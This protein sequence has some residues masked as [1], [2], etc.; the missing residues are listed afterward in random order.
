MLLASL[1]ILAAAAVPASTPPIEVVPVPADMAP[2][3]PLPPVVILLPPAERPILFLDLPLPPTELPDSIRNLARV[4]FDAGDDATWQRI[5]KLSRET[6]PQARAQI[7]AIEAEYTARRAE[8]LARAARERAERLAA[9]SM[10]DNWKGEVELGG[11]RLTGNTDS[12][13]IFGAVRLD[14]EGLKWKHQL[15]GRVDFQRADDET[16][17]DRLKLGWQPNY[18]FNEKSF[19]YGLGQYERDRFLGFSSRYTL[20]SGIG[21]GI[22]SKP[23]TKLSIQGGP[24]IRYTDYVDKPARSSAAGRAS[25]AFRWKLTP[26]LSFAQDAAVY[27]EEGTRNAASASSLETQVIGN[28]KARLAYDIQYEKSDASTRKPLDTTS[29]VTLVYGF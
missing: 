11:S 19:V 23:D 1:A 28:L 21:F 10:L 13:A 16:T 9:A 18:K 2:L 20:S 15:R 5:L 24:A 8:Q 7:E 25:I 14:R 12:L 17:V 29:R 26:T 3:P 6:N 4:A 27:L 22:I